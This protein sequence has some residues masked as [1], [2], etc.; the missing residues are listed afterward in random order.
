LYGGGGGGGVRHD[1]GTNVNRPGGN[2]GSGSVLIRY[3]GNT[4]VAAGGDL[5][6]AGN[7]GYYYHWFYSTGT[8][9][10]TS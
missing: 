7:D 8:F 4:P 2:G 3:L 10:Y 9:T 5:V 1:G 6:F